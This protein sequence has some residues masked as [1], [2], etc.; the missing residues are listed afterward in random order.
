M[1]Y[2]IGIL[3]AIALATVGIWLTVEAYLGGLTHFANPQM[4]RASQKMQAASQIIRAEKRTKGLLQSLEIDPNQT[5]LIGPEYT[6]ITT[7]LGI[8]EAKRT[9]TNPDLAATIVRTIAN[10]GIKPPGPVVILMSGSLVGANIAAITATEALGLHPLLISSL[11]SSMFGATD[12]ELTWLDIENLLHEHSLIKARSMIAVIGGGHARGSGLASE[13][14]DAIKAS[15]VRH[16]IP[17]LEADNVTD[18][19]R[20]LEARIAQA[21]PSRIALL[22]NVGGSVVGL[23]TCTNGHLLPAGIIQDQ[24]MCNDGTPGLILETL[25]NN[26]P[27]LHLLNMRSLAAKWGLPYD[28]IPLPVPGNNKLVYG[29]SPGAVPKLINSDQ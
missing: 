1:P 17:L 11:G 2:S 8:L 25:N 24:F 9:A 5:G 3:A 6:E 27:V 26:I 7:S 4:Q 13:G 15:M 23:G 18:I 29:V 12:P 10:M 22:I 19:V 16:N 20:Q 21:A 14:R 28:P